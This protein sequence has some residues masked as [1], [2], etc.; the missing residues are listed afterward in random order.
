M[1]VRVSKHWS[2]KTYNVDLLSPNGR[3]GDYMVV[4]K[5]FDVPIGEAQAEAQ[6]V[7]NL[8][9]ATIEELEL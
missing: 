9:G 3:K 4:G 7:A 2:G 6:R 5:A 1:I 8:Y